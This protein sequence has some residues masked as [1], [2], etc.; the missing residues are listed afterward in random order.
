MTDKNFNKTAGLFTTSRASRAVISAVM[1]KGK[2]ITWGISQDNKGNITLQCSPFV[3]SQVTPGYVY[4]LG[5]KERAEKDEDGLAH[6]F[7]YNTAQTPKLVVPVTIDDFYAL[8]GKIEL[9]QS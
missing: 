1:P 9:V 3:L 7:K 2:N 4:V 8:G 5:D 6:Q